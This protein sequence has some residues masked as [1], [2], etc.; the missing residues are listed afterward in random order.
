MSILQEE[1]RLGR[2]ICLM[3]PEDTYLIR[4]KTDE[5]TERWYDAILSEAIT[6][7]ALKLGRPVFALEFFG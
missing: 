7:R 5:D 4:A 1:K 2:C 3:M 6:A